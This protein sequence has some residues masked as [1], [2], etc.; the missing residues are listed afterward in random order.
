[1]AQP[2]G[3]A[4]F[5]ANRCWIIQAASGALPPPYPIDGMDE[6]VAVGWLCRHHSYSVIGDP[7]MGQGVVGREAF[8]AGKPFVG[9]ELNRKRLAVLVEHIRS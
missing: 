6:S 9:T 4:R 7:C 8:A 2:I 1:L 3:W 5:A